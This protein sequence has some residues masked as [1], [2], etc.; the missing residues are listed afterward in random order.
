MLPLGLT[1]SQ[2]D[3]L[4]AFLAT[5]TSPEYASA[6]NEELDLQR[7]R[8]KTTRPQRDNAAAMGKSGLGPG[9]KGPFGDMGPA[10]TEENPALLGGD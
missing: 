5:L 3:D 7:K 2:E 8:A 4:V 6:A 9:F 1:E 10:Q